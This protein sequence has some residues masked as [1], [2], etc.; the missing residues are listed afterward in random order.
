MAFEA[1]MREDNAPPRLVVFEGPA[2]DLFLL[3]HPQLG[4]QCAADDTY[5]WGQGRDSRFLGIWSPS[6]PPADWPTVMTCLIPIP[7]AWAAYFLDKPNFGVA[8]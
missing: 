5:I 7:M 3:L 2:M 8:P 4:S 6:D 1:D